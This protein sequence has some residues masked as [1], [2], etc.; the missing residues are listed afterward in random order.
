VS[1]LPTVRVKR[2]G[3]K[4][5]RIINLSSFNPEIHEP[6]DD[7][8]RALVAHL[9]P[10]ESK[11]LGDAP[12]LIDIPGDWKSLHWKTRV[13]LAEKLNGDAVLTPADG[14][15]Q[16]DAADAVIEAELARRA[17]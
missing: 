1:S 16:A 9:M 11:P 5:S 17:A 8:A 6:A 10:V 3:P 14:Q 15:T 4:G 2:D 13:S 7:E 12:A